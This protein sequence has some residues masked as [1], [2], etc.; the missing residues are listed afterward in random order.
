MVKK[1]IGRYPTLPIL[2]EMQQNHNK[3]VV[4]LTPVKMAIIVKSTN[5]KC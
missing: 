2:R 4:H 5:N 3:A 1:H